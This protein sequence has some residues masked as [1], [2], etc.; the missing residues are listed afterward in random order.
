MQ[1][2]DAAKK[3]S[4]H[5][6]GP[7]QSR[8]RR[9]AALAVGVLLTAGVCA[10]VYMSVSGSGA[11]KITDESKLAAVRRGNLIVSVNESG[12][13]EAE[14]RTVISN[15]L[16]WPVIIKSVVSN[17]TLV[18]EG[19]KIIEF[20]CKAL[21]DEIEEEEYE[22]ETDRLS[23]KQA[24]ESY[25]L[26]KKEMA[27]KV[28]QAE[29]AL[30]EAQEDLSRYRDAG[31]QWEIQKND[32][33]SEIQ[34]AQQNLKLA[35]EKLEF[36]VRV[37]KDPELKSPYSK[38]E[39]EADRLEVRRL[40]LALEKAIANKKMLIKYDHPRELRRLKAA[41]D[42]ARLD[43]ERAKLEAE[44]EL[45]L[46]EA[47]L[48]NKKQRL[49]R[50]EKK[51]KELYEDRERLTIKAEKDGLVVYDTGGSR[52]RPSDVEVEVGEEIRPRQQL[53]IIPDMTTLQVETKVFEA[54]V[55]RLN[56]SD[57][58]QKATRAIVRLDVDQEKPLHGHVKWVAPI[59]ESQ[60]RFG[61]TGA[62]TFKV[63]V[64]TD[65]LPDGV[66][67]GMT[68]EVELILNRLKN[69]LSVPVAAVFTEQDNTFCWKLNDG[70][71]RKTPVTVGN[72]NER[73]V[74]IIDGLAEGDKVLLV[75]PETAPGRQPEPPQSGQEESSPASNRPRR[76]QNTGGNR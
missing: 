71:P 54:V 45:S 50:G 48:R 49:E 35:E 52:W 5:S 56:A 76:P 58:K 74:Q 36:K 60:H 15:E 42:A 47:E 72:S 16:E 12:E 20:E 67:P 7:R 33:E 13:I 75:P 37:N 21:M 10:A 44:T 23:Y 40:K 66:K 73:R 30:L 61:D 70:H 25:E 19:Q 63:N 6:N 1:Q 62:K 39:I 26:K 51:L 46:A 65:H 9:A 27:N 17:G 68:A 4:P 31:G 59:P 29:N 64:A 3:S 2:S 28:T 24:A 55:N 34:L 14:K 41:V 8:R 53:M 57:D 43:L 38:N 18:S 69:V 32:A 22:V 11:E